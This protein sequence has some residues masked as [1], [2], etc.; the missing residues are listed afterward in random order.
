MTQGALEDNFVYQEFKKLINKFNI[1]KI[2]ETG[3]YYGWSTV[4]LAEFG[5]EVITIE[6]S[7]DNYNIANKNFSKTSFSNIRSLLGD[8]PDILREILSNGDNDIILFLDAHWYNYWPIHDELRVCIEK[9]IK[10]V[11]I[12]HDFF[13]P[14]ENGNAKFGFDKYE[15]QSLDLNYIKSFL[16]E[17]YGEDNYEYYYNSKSDNV[18]Q[19]VI[20]IYKKNE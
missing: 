11:I 18:G 10:P 3:T 12:I 19:G 13:V 15:Q 7:E 17:I 14:D 4:K 16:N 1:K 2:I 8:S 9:K 20:Y 5:I 6:S